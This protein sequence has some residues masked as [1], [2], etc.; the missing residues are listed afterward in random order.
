MERARR[1]A[2]IA[3]YTRRRY[4]L[5]Q[6]ARSDQRADLRRKRKRNRVLLGEIIHVPLKNGQQILIGR[7][8]N[9]IQFVPRDHE[10]CRRLVEQERAVEDLSGTSL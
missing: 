1:K 2:E 5:K 10:A 7:L 9:G 3:R 8:A 4:L 6:D